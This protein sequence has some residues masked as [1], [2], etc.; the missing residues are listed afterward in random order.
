LARQSMQLEL[1]A[2]EFES[3]RLFFTPKE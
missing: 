3:L 1:A 2:A